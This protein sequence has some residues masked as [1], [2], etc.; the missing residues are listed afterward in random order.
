M[1]APLNEKKDAIY[2]MY[3]DS[4]SQGEL[5]TITLALVKENNE[6]EL[7]ALVYIRDVM[8]PNVN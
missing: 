6:K 7:L 2:Q 1:L 3:H 8:R 4:I 5:R